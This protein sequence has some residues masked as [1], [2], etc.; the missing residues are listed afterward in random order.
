VYNPFTS[1]SQE[2]TLLLNDT[3]VVLYENGSSSD[4][5]LY[6]AWLGNTYPANGT[7]LTFNWF[8]NTSNN[9]S[10]IVDTNGNTILIYIDNATERVRYFIPSQGSPTSADA[11]IA[12]NDTAFYNS[13]EFESCFF[14]RGLDINQ[15]DDFSTLFMINFVSSASGM[16]II[17]F[18]YGSSPTP[19]QTTSYDCSVIQ[20]TFASDVNQNEYNNFI[21][22]VALTF[23]QAARTLTGYSLYI[24]TENVNTNAITAY[25]LVLNT[26]TVTQANIV[27][28]NTTISG[29]EYMPLITITFNNA[30]VKYVYHLAIVNIGSS[31]SYIALYPYISGTTIDY[32]NSPYATTQSFYVAPFFFYLD[33]NYMVFAYNDVNG[34]AQYLIYD[35]SQSAAQ[36]NAVTAVN[37]NLLSFN[38]LVNQPTFLMSDTKFCLIDNSGIG[39]YSG[40]AALIAVYD[41]SKYEAIC[42]SDAWSGIVQFFTCQC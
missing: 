9:M 38:L 33:R 4:N 21:S 35:L 3:L 12:I 41:F 42:C 20:S 8:D 32:N 31:A 30:N 39:F 17:K 36:I 15:N 1:S 7:T 40:P 11:G 14:L 19:V 28:T 6:Y 27:A 25:E 24:T 26:N 37:P 2:D 22:G 10:Y 23:G 13:H 34:F 16:Q 29:N 5:G 18:N